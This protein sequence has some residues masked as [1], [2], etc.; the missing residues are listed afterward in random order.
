MRANVRQNSRVATLRNWKHFLQSYY[1]DDSDEEGRRLE[2][3]VATERGRTVEF[4]TEMRRPSS[5]M[6]KE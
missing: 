1:T 6:T 4:R 2:S 3:L 5:I